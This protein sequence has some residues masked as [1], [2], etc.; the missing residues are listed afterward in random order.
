MGALVKPDLLTEMSGMHLVHHKLDQLE[1]T[2]KETTW[3]V[4]LNPL[5]VKIKINKQ[6]FE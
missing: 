6:S 1:P 5:F 4:I 2:K 3:R